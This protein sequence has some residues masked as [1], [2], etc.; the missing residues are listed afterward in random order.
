MEQTQTLIGIFAQVKTMIRSDHAAALL[1]KNVVYVYNA[2]LIFIM[3]K[4]YHLNDTYYST[5]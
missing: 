1:I 5:S 2:N 4:M 3:I